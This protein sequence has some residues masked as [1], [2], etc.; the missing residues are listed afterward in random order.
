MTSFPDPAIHRGFAPAS[1]RPAAFLRSPHVQTVGGKYLRPSPR[2]RL[3]RERW[4]TPDGD[5]LDVDFAA[6]SRTEA[7]P[8]VL[9]LHGLEGSTARPYV[10]LAMDELLDRGILPVGLNFR[11][12]SGEPNRA[13]TF[14]HSGD[15]RDL[16][17][18]L[19]ELAERFPSHPLGALGFSLGGNVL[20]KYLAEEAQARR[21]VPIRAAA[22]ISVPFDLAAGTACLEGTVMGKLYTNYFL[23]SL[24]RKVAAKR[25]R[26]PHR[27]DLSRVEAAR[28]LREFDEHFTAPLHG[29]DG[30]WDYYAQ[31][32]SGPLLG[33]VRIPTFVIHA[34]DD[35]FLPPA[36][37]P[38][39]MMED[40]PWILPAVLLR[41]G[42]V[43]F[44]QHKEGFAKGAPGRFWAEAEAARYLKA[45]LDPLD[46][47][48]LDPDHQGA[49]LLR[50]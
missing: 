2:H 40:N 5:F 18:A 4:E 1:F 11:S 34:L 9:I 13:A 31:S 43:G 10:R 44:L 22:A 19:G 38:R 26:I 41:G 23:R 42:H 25:D 37:V 27:V 6:A 35:P 36:A 3:L 28:T 20:L 39:A 21:P 7:S 8:M 50:P 49:P 15:T 30:A 48:P 12:C 17:W 33:D 14:Y 29:F 46:L 47:D 16:R 45:M 24:L 32:S